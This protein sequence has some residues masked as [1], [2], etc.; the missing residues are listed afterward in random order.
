M[1]CLPCSRLSTVAKPSMLSFSTGVEV[2][3]LS[4]GWGTQY[5]PGAAAVIAV[6]DSVTG[7][8][9]DADGVGVV[10]AV[11]VGA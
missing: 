10:A 3:L 1:V 5:D 9:G 11:G 6:M 8:G 2:E 4:I 7:V